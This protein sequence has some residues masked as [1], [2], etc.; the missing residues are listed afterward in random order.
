MLDPFAGF[1]RSVVSH[2][3]FRTVQLL[4][5]GTL[6]S[7]RTLRFRHELQ[8]SDRRGGLRRAG[9]TVESRGDGSG[10]GPGSSLRLAKEAGEGGSIGDGVRY[11][12]VLDPRLDLTIV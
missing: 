9:S 8:A 12:S 2:V 1:L 4:H 11:G 5:L 6:A 7:Q 3:S 10:L